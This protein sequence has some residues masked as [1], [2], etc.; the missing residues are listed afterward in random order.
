MVRSSPSS[1]RT[2]SPARPASS[3]MR[4]RLMGDGALDPGQLLVV[5][6]AL[7]DV[8][9]RQVGELAA[10]SGSVRC[11]HREPALGRRR[12]RRIG[13]DGLAR[14]QLEG[15]AMRRPRSGWKR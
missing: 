13:I 7:V 14:V 5:A 6:P 2:S 15:L 10:R 1:I 9:L 4:P 3:T 11:E 12:S 8:G